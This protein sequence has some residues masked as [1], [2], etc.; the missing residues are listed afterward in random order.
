MIK[1]SGIFKQRIG[2]N[3][4]G[5]LNTSEDGSSARCSTQQKWQEQLSMSYVNEYFPVYV[6][7]DVNIDIYIYIYCFFFK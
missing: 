2:K 7:Y 6:I 4:G 1:N 5:I 3:N